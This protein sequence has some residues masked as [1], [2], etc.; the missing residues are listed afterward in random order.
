[1]VVEAA[2]ALLGI[3]PKRR[4]SRIEPYVRTL[5]IADIAHSEA[6]IKLVAATNELAHLAIE[7]DKKKKGKDHNES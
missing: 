1:M 6:I 4:E 2:M 7:E 3:I 5:A